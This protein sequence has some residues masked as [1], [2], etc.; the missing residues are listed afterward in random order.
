M[1]RSLLLTGAGPAGLGL[2]H[3]FRLR[4]RRTL[5]T[6]KRQC[7]LNSATSAPIIA[8]LHREQQEQAQL[9]EHVVDG[10][11]IDSL[12]VL[13]FHG[14][15]DI[16]G[17]VASEA[18]RS[19]ALVTVPISSALAVAMDE[20]GGQLSVLAPPEMPPNVKKAIEGG[21]RGLSR[22]GLDSSS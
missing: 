3:Q 9:L 15:D 14:S 21:A 8:P 2:I 22:Q 6:P 18:V 1:G 4:G 11:D 10:L 12:A 19:A 13:G 20:D 5:C 7:K 17:L 16:R